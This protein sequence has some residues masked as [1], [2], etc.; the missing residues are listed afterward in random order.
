VFCFLIPNA[1]RV[2]NSF[3]ILRKAIAE[4]KAFDSNPERIA[5]IVDNNLNV[6]SVCHES[7]AMSAD[8]A[9]QS[10]GRTEPDQRS[11]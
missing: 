1:R 7:A 2:N 8:D 4:G 9:T 5:H 6:T 3:R 10:G 11:R